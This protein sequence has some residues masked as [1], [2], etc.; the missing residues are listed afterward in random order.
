MVTSIEAPRL[1][2]AG[3]TVIVSPAGE[4]T[5]EAR[6]WYRVA[7]RSIRVRINWTRLGMISEAHLCQLKIG[8]Q[9][10]DELR[11]VD[12]IRNGRSVRAPGRVFRDQSW[13]RDPHPGIQQIEMFVA[14][15]IHTRRSAALSELAR[16][17][18]CSHQIKSGA[19]RV[20]NT[21]AAVSAARALVAVT[22]W[23]V[24]STSAWSVC[25][26]GLG[27]AGETADASLG[28]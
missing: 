20:K 1:E 27:V 9:D 16:C 5:I 13:R 10:G 17:L 4:A 6:S 26:A 11:A 7:R 24:A 19:M 23:W 21:S 14:I 3:R 12:A 28:V 2:S 25:G 18:L 15:S 8:C 22:S